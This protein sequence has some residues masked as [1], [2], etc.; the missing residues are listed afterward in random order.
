MYST[1]EDAGVVWEKL[2]PISEK[3]TIA[4]KPTSK[5]VRVLPMQKLEEAKLPFDAVEQWQS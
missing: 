4:A 2:K 3:V 1:P 5:I